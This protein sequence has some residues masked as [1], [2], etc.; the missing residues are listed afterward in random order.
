MFLNNKFDAKQ[1]KDLNMLTN[2]NLLTM[3]IFSNTSEKEI[4]KIA[5][6][7]QRT[8]I[9]NATKEDLAAM[10]LFACLSE[11]EIEKI[12]PIT[13]KKSFL[14]DTPLINQTD[15]GGQFFLLHKGAVKI[16]HSIRENQVQILAVHEKGDFFGEASFVEGKQRDT[17]AICTADSVISIIYKKDFDKLAEESPA[18]GVKILKVLALSICSNLRT[19]TTKVNTMVQYVSCS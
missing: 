12:T 14:R 19:L 1:G 8:D 10:P 11:E 4:E 5:S 17:S 16:I 3:P 18:L 2:D 13:H 15:S 9:D 6:V 7:T